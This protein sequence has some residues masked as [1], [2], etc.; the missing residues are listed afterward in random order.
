MCSH[1]V[2]GGMGG[3]ASIA[4]VSAS[5]RSSGRQ[6]NTRCAR[7]LARAKN[8]ASW[9]LKSAGEAKVRPG[10]KERSR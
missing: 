6:P 2:V 4:A 5:T 3:R 8:A 1:P 10:R 9:V 7:A